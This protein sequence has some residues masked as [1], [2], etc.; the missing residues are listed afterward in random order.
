MSNELSA[1]PSGLGQMVKKIG[2]IFGKNSNFSHKPALFSSFKIATRINT[3]VIMAIVAM[4]AIFGLTYYQKIAS[5][6]LLAQQEQVRSLGEQAINLEKDFLRFSTQKQEFFT[7]KDI[8]YAKQVS[9]SLEK[10]IKS[11]NFMKKLPGAE[12]VDNEINALVE[13][14]LEIG[15]IFDELV[16]SQ[17]KLGFTSK[18]GMHKKFHFLGLKVEAKLMKVN[19]LDALESKVNMMRRYEGEFLVSHNSKMLGKMTRAK[20]L[21]RVIL[22]NSDLGKEKIDEIG[23]AINDYYLAFKDYSKEIKVL[24]KTLETFESSFSALEPKFKALRVAADIKLEIVAAAR[25]KSDENLTTLI[26][27]AVGF[28]MVLIISFGW[29]I[30][31][32]ISKP[33]AR[34][35]GLMARS[36]KGEIGLDIPATSQKDEVGDIARALEI[37]DMNNAEVD[38]LKQREENNRKQAATDR[39]DEL[40]SIAGSLE[41][42]VQT[43][44]SNVSAQSKTMSSESI[45]LDGIIDV[46]VTHTSN[47]NE[48][49]SNISSQINMIASASEELSCSIAEVS[50]QVEKSS[51][52]SQNAVTQSTQTNETVKTLASS[53]QAIGEVVKLIS[54]IAEQTN[55]LA[56]NATI[57]AAR[58]GDAGKGFAVVASEVKNLASQTAQATVEISNQINTI[59]EVTNVTVTAI[60]EIS[61]TV[62]D[63]GEITSQI[64]M[65]VEQQSAATS[66]ISRNVQEAAQST[67]EFTTILQSVSDQTNTVGD[68]SSTVMSEADK[69]SGQIGELGERMNEVIDTLQKSA[70]AA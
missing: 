65:A 1:S 62:R 10:L 36:S 59:Q 39:S 35:V 24:N 9:G 53:A 61:D 12:A 63:M 27:S 64:Q 30:S 47:A 54:D 31:R 55:L 25:V 21:L 8:Y 56:L 14:G 2:Q 49:A 69:T 45:R 7:K 58:A 13:N 34:I 60:G 16:I 48:N 38:R 68:I 20:S 67:D 37:F 3:L 11:L 42:Q 41:T 33:L 43:V 15:T 19:N 17:E 40:N 52:I 57:E 22:K 50:E 23:G 6:D 18:F 32:S 70:N 5:E 29:L 4:M 46:L 51:L 44:V 66:E 26:L 28:I